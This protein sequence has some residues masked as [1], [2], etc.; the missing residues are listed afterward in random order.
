[1]YPIHQIEKNKDQRERNY[2]QAFYIDWAIFQNCPINVKVYG[3]KNFALENYP[4]N[5]K[6]LHIGY[7]QAFYIDFFG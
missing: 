7:A 1:M 4:I 6:C 5:A 3:K 2:K